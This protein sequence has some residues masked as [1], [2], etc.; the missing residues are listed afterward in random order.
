MSR[1][2][3][4]VKDKNDTDV[5]VYADT[6]IV[7]NKEMVFPKKEADEIHNMFPFLREKL[8]GDSP[9]ANCFE[10]Y[11]KT[12]GGSFFTKDE[13]ALIEKASKDSE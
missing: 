6:C 8:Q 11:Q 12:I 13:I 5:E 9:C 10:E 7:C 4:I 2:I 1:I 3:K